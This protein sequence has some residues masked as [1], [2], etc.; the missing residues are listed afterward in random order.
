ML[1][2]LSWGFSGTLSHVMTMKVTTPGRGHAIP[3]YGMKEEADLGRGFV[4]VAS[5]VQKL[6]N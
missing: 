4:P 2:I 5:V 1:D 6:I 3:A